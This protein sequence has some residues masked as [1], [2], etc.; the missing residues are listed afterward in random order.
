MSSSKFRDT[1]DNIHSR[2]PAI[3]ASHLREAADIIDALTARLASAAPVGRLLTA[4]QIITCDN[5]PQEFED[6]L[7]YQTVSGILI[8]MTDD[9]VRAA[10]SML[11]NAVEVRKA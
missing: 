6:D 2:G 1:A 11:Y 4:G 7:N 3:A 10:G 8:E 5:Y 9:N